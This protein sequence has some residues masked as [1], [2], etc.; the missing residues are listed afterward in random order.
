MKY[1]DEINLDRDIEDALESK[2]GFIAIDPSDPKSKVNGIYSSDYL[3]LEELGIISLNSLYSTEFPEPRWLIDKIL[4]YNGI[5]A[6]SGVPKTG[7]SML[8]LH[9]ARCIST[10]SRFLGEFDTQQGG[11]LI[12]NKEDP[13]RLIQERFK[14]LDQNGNLPVYFCTYNNLYLD[15]D[16]YIDSLIEFIKQNDIKLVIFDSF[17]RIFK[18]EENSSQVIS[19]VHSRLKKL[20]EN[21]DLS[22]LFIHHHGKEGMFKRRNIAEK[23]RGSSDI[24][25]MLD[26]LLVVETKD[27]ETLTITQAALRQDKPLQPFSINRKADG[28]FEFM[29]HLESEKEIAEEIKELILDFL[30]DD[31]KITTEILAYSAQAGYRE[32][33]SKYALKELLISK[34]VNRDKSSRPYKYFLFETNKQSQ[35]KQ[36]TLNI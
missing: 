35:T 26:C 6:I 1:E 34:K 28:S 29:E 24:L 33:T 32:T 7:K 14:S 4:P 25:A 23:L 11:V 36:D 5:T 19:E 8:S 18:G 3:T 21:K 22:I 15:T 13:L 2:P 9:L 10:G 16:K 12:I 20:I 30:K 17:R 31:P 27:N